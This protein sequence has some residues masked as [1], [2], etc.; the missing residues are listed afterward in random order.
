MLREDVLALALAQT[1]VRS[2]A[3]LGLTRRE[4]E[5]ARLVVRGWTARQIAD[6]LV[7]TP[8]TAEGHVS[9]LLAKLGLSSRAQLAVWAADH[10]LRDAGE[11]GDFV[12]DRSNTQF[13]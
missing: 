13:T 6:E 2:D 11:A 8:R 10:G 1:A 9:N 4:R 12:L 5:V 3:S 7:V